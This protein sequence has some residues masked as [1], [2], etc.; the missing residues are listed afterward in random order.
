MSRTLLV[1][2]DH[3]DF[4]ALARRVLDGA[5]FTVVAEAGTAREAL[6]LAHQLRPEVVVLDV[7]LPDGNGFDVAQT[8][9]QA[10]PPPAVVLVSSRDW[11]QLSRRVRRS[12][13]R[14]FLPK[15]ELTAAAVERLLA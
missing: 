5:A 1:V 14:G 6:L 13:A 15:E 9:V 2:D 8:L 11:G 3:A 7:A 10:D 4:R 12:G